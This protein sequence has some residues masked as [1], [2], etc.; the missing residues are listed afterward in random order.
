MPKDVVRKIQEAGFTD[1]K[2]NKHTELWKEL[3]AKNKLKHY[4]TDIAGRWYWYQNW[5]DD[6]ISYLK[7]KQL[8]K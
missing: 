5:I 3:D 4:G 7:N 2:M 6:A 8:E 1:F